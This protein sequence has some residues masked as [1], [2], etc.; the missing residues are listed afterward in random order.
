MLLNSLMVLNSASKLRAGFMI[1]N[2]QFHKKFRPD[3]IKSE[4]E[5]I[6]RIKKKEQRI[7]Q[8]VQI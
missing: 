4:K 3:A 5:L 2:Q 6:E 8:K 7:A 1:K